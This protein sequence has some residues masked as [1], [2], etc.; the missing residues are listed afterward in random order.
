MLNND[1]GHIHLFGN[2]AENFYALGKRDKNAFA[3]VYEQIS[4][5]CI[6]NDFMSKVLKATSELSTRFNK[7]K[8]GPHFDDIK[9][10]AEGLERPVEDVIFTM[11]MPEMVASFNKW[12]PDL[13]SLL[14]GCSS[15]FIW[16]KKNHGSIHTRILDYALSGPFEK[17]ERSILYDFKDRYKIFSYGSAG[18]AL[19]GLT[20]MN[21]QGLT[22]ALHYKHGQYFNLE[23]ESIFFI[24]SEILSECASGREAIKLLRSKQSISFW[25]LYLTDKNGEVTSID[26]CGKELH[27]EKFDLKD[28]PYLYFNN[29]ALLKKP[30]HEN[31]QPYGNLEQCL[32]RTQSLKKRMDNIQLDSSKDLMEESLNILGAPHAKK[33][34]TAAKWVLP[35]ITPSSI[36]LCSFH[37][38]L[39]AAYFVSGAAPKFFTGNYLKQTNLFNQLDTKQITKKIKSDKYLKGHKYLSDFQT[40]L[41]KNNVTAAYHALQMSILYLED[42]EE[43]SV[44]KFYFHILEYIYESDKRDLSYLYQDFQNLEG[45]LPPYLNDHRLLF[46]LRTSKLLNQKVVNN[47]QQISNQGLKELYRKEFNLN[48]MAIKG[49]KFLIYPRIEILDIIYAY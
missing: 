13:L 42:F 11:L 17:F 39:N 46:M 9:S 4:R 37:N 31:M 35:T 33:V 5:L 26:I 29:R 18:I 12:A 2:P 40:Q 8:H 14:P 36:Q 32:M 1:L 41:D 10:Y 15:L 19:P 7:K 25:G 28:H 34:H 30:E 22:L 43:V 24:A 6:R 48:A 47:V 27:Q 49:L 45:K 38:S 21:D 16:D 20:A 44:L 3:E 23:G